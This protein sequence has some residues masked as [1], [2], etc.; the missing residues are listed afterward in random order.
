VGVRHLDPKEVHQALTVS[1]LSSDTLSAP[2]LQ[3]L[4]RAGLRE[5]FQSEP[6]AVL[7]ALHTGLPTA[8]ESDRLYA[9]AEL[10]F[11]HASKARLQEYYL[12]AALYAYAF[13]FPMDNRASPQRFDPRTRTAFDLYNR[14][15]AEGFTVGEDRRVVIE[16]GTYKLPFGE[17]TI[18]TAPEDL[19]WGIYRLVDFVQA[20]ELDVVGLRNRYRWPG[21]GAPL[22]ASLQ[23]MEDRKIVAYHKVPA[24]IKV[25]VTAFLRP[26]N[27]QEILKTG[28]LNGRLELYTVDEATSI[29]INGQEIPLEYELSS[30]LA[31][32]VEGSH[33]YKVELK[34]FF[35]GNFS[36]F[37]DKARFEDG[38]FFIEPYRPG[39]I[40][41]VLVHGT[42]SSP[43][44]WAEMLNELQNDHRLWGRYQF[45]LFTYNT[46]N[47]ILYSGG[48]LAESL[49][50][51]VKELDPEGRDDAL[52]K[53]VIIGH[54]QG[55]LLAKLTAVDSGMCFWDKSFSKPLD[56]LAVSPEAK[57]IL[58]RSMCYEPVPSL[59]RVVFIA[60][61]HRGSF[62]AGGWIG[63]LA[64]KFIS[65]PFQVL[66]PIREAVAASF[67]AQDVQSVKK[68][69]P[70]T[71]N[72][73]PNSW[74]IQTLSSIPLAEN[75]T[76]H[77]IIAVKNPEA[78]KE[79]WNDGV[80]NYSSA[81]IEGVASECVVHSS[82]STQAKPETIEEVRRILIQHLEE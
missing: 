38:L 48:I 61:P 21:I 66:E 23:I 13:L 76:A 29:P 50:K 18:A 60:T 36:I 49:K 74:L 59:R 71:D 6:D 9:L 10:S 37:K 28:R 70:S 67:M 32:T 40:P 46:G 69:Q 25:A 31:Y 55:G 24:Q 68:V 63:R 47:P 14:A 27:L 17:I 12:A 39:C 11:A 57:R 45:W 5:K 82:H 62:V 8:G 35:S 22:A 16:G 72:M 56:E 73:N 20:A 53:M 34:G 42:A 81:H 30:A 4:N 51:V 79:K 43:V 2:T 44:R 77:S 64:G 15:I 19:Q 78:P 1:V 52:R 41:V 65:L 26:D 54:S 7:S 80:V 3:I 75:I 58:Q 33:L